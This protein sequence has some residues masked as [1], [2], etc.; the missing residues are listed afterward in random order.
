M[1]RL[2]ATVGATVA[3]K[4]QGGGLD[5][6]KKSAM[7][8]RGQIGQALAVAALAVVAGCGSG[9]AVPSLTAVS[10]V[11][12]THIRPAAQHYGNDW[13]Y[14]TTPG[15]GDASVYHKKGSNLKYDKSLSVDLSSPEGSVATR[16]GWW[17]V[18]N[19]GAAN[20]LVYRSTAKGPQGPIGTPLDDAAELPFDVAVTPS[21]N[22]VA[23]SNASGVESGTGSVSVYLDRATE[24]SRLLTYGS[25]GNT[26]AGIA[27]DPHGNCYWSFNELGTA[28]DFG[29]IVEFANC[30]GS[31]KLVVNS[32]VTAAG[33]A[34]DNRG[35]LYYIDETV[36]V[37]KC[38]GLTN[39]KLF[40][41][42]FGL[43]VSLNFD[44]NYRHLW[45]ADATGFLDAVNPGTGSIES[46]TPSVNGDPYGIAPSPGS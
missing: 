29:S 9:S 16:S 28:S 6:L 5:L 14:S 10:P 34:F 1:G 36:G 19:A 21:R 13:M 20:V 39:C 26:G 33:V 31:G 12:L 35:N 43:P 30:S 2:T 15:T 41:T 40:A 17:Y 44:A 11:V 18:A 42:G 27:I 7:L 3:G 8:H 4:R 37:Y 22:L 24:P 46:E 25:D 23:V 32:I 38:R 45:V